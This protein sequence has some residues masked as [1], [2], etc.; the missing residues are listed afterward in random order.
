MQIWPP[1]GATCISCKFDHQMAPLALVA[2]LATRWRHLHWLQIWPPD[3]ATCISS[4]VG[5]QVVSLALPHCL[6]RLYWHYQLVLSWYLH[7]PESHQ[8]SLAVKSGK[9]GTNASGA[10]W[11][12]NWELMQVVPS[13]GQNCNQCKWCHLVAKF[14]TNSS[15]AIW[16]PNLQPIQV[17][18]SGGQICN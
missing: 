2:N 15:G 17:V 4:K 12:P 9:V 8:L 1:D 3:G 16:W 13:G 11:W 18:P 7:Q 6:G 5:H 14:A 10:I